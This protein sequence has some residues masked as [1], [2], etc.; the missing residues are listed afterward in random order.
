LDLEVKYLYAKDALFRC[1]S[2]FGYETLNDKGELCL[3][4]LCESALERAFSS[5]GIEEDII[6]KED[7]YKLW[8][9]NNAKL[10]AL[11]QPTIQLS[12][13]Q[14]YMENKDEELKQYNIRKN[15]DMEDDDK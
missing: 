2:Q 8:D 14:T 5:L 10:K 13:Y 11:N 1:I 3:Y 12:Y 15:W 7:F 6:T 9:E 4:D